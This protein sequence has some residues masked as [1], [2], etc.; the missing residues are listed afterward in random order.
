MVFVDCEMQTEEQK[1]IPTSLQQGI[2]STLAKWY[3]SKVS[4][5]LLQSK[6]LRLIWTKDLAV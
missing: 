2:S 6:F 1:A 5:S 4:T 3:K